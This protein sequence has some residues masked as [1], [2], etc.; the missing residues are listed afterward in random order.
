MTMLLHKK[1]LVYITLSLL[2][3]ASFSLADDDEASDV[4]VLTPDNFDDFLADPATSIIEFY[5]PWCGHCKSFAPEY[6]KIA[7]TLKGE[8]RVAKVDADEHKSLG[9]KFDVQGFPTII[10]HKDGT[11]HTYKGGRSHDALIARAREIA[12][13]SFVPPVSA[14]AELTTENFDSFMEEHDFVLMMFYAPWCGHCKKIKPAYEEAAEQLKEMHAAGEIDEKHAVVPRLAK[15]DATE[16]GD[17]ASRFGVSGY[18]TL[19]IFRKGNPSDYKGGREAHELVET[20]MKESGPASKPFETVNAAKKL[21]TKTRGNNAKSLLVG[22][23]ADEGDDYEKFS[24]IANQFRED[25]IEVYHTTDDAVKAGINCKNGDMFL[26]H[27]INFRSK[28]EPERFPVISAEDV[29]NNKT[30]LLGAHLADTRTALYGPGKPQIIIVGHIDFSFKYQ[31]AAQQIRSK[32]LPV[33]NKLKSK[34]TFATL[35]EDDFA[36]D[37]KRFGLEDSSEDLN[38]VILDGKKAYPFECEDGLNAEVLTEVIEDYESGNLKRHLKSAKP[39]KKNNGPVK[40]VVSTQFDKIVMDKKKD[41]LIE[42]YA[43]WCGH[44]KALEPVFKKLGKNRASE[45]DLT[46]AKFDAIANDVPDDRFDVTGFPTLYYVN[47]ANKIEKY[48]GG[49]EL[50]DF[51]KFLDEKRGGAAKDEL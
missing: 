44:C 12:D 49:R 48:E 21:T 10:I 46:I 51:Y 4:V 5:A 25:W 33:A 11:G 38:I 19:K 22:C 6:E 15:L 45:G 3:L 30:P 31:K 18:P 42:F 2:L 1:L 14:V 39:P 9:G 23:F 37:V 28:F 32:I 50:K 20:I 8:I 16:H 43:P 35:N 26:V 34:Y 24:A 27:D 13:P 36:D 47:K 41:V 29:T 40:V 7:S 17:I